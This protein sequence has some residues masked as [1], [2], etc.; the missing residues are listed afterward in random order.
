MIQDSPEWHQWRLSGVGA[1]EIA[2]I[3]GLCP[4][5]GTPYKVWQVKTKRA[6]GFEGNSFTEHG[7]ET[8]AKARARYELISMEDMPPAC[9]THPKYNYLIA[10]L[11]GWNPELKKILEIKCPKG[12]S[13][14]EAAS[15]GK[16]I[17]HY[18]PQVQHQLL[19]TGADAVDFFVYHEESGRDAL[20]TVYP[21][22]ALQAQILLRVGKFWRDHVLADVPPPL[23]EEDVKV[24]DD[25]SAKE[26]SEE[27]LAKV[28]TASKNEIDS[29][30]QKLILIGGHTKVKCGR[31]QV[32]TVLRKGKFSYYKLTISG[33]GA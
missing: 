23:T 17:D 15:A 7:K 6:K 11:D 5:G 10:S 24:T 9:A 2:S 14:I 33:V 26:V 21:D 18:I 19:V 25:L 3:L 31:V 32:S 8:E 30:K 13:T 29:L 20:V 16:V 28:E 4:Y 1:S 22:L 12:L 27:I